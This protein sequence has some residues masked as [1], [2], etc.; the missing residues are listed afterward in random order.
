MLKTAPKN[1]QTTTIKLRFGSDFSFGNT[2]GFKI[3]KTGVSLV[4]CNFT[5]SNWVTTL[6][7]T[8]PAVLSSDSKRVC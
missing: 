5:C 8:T 3:E 6:S 2:T 1:N 4:T 7:K